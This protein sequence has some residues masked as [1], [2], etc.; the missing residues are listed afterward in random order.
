M[1]RKVMKTRL[2]LQAELDEAN[3][4][5][6]ELQDKLD[7]IAGIAGGDKESYDEEDEN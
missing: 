6:E 4:L 5:I 1:P 3:E 7:D 2:E